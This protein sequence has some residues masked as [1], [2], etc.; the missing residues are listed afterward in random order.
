MTTQIMSSANVQQ[1]TKSS[2]SSRSSKSASTAAKSSKS[3]KN[4]FGDM[5]DAATAKDTKEA[6][7]LSGNAAA[8]GKDADKDTGLPGKGDAKD[9]GDAQGQNDA[10]QQLMA[11]ANAQNA[12]NPAA[13]QETETVS[14][15]TAAVVLDLQTLQQTEPE[16]P[17][18][19]ALLPQDK[20]AGQKSQDF[21]A[22]L[23]GQKITGAEDVAFQQGSGASKSVAAQNAATSLL[24]QTQT[25]DGSQMATTTVVA[26]NGQKTLTPLEASLAWHSAQDALQANAAVPT[27]NVA[28]QAATVAEAPVATALTGLQQVTA[29][30]ATAQKSEETQDTTSLLG[31]AALT[32]DSEPQDPLRVMLHQA[33]QDGRGDAQPNAQQQDAALFQQEDAQPAEQAAPVASEAPETPKSAQAPQQAPAQHTGASFAQTLTN[34]QNV[35]QT[36]APQEVSQART[37]YDIPRQIVDQARLIQRGQDTEMV[38]HLKPEHLGDLTLKV[39]VT[40]NGSVNASFHSQSAEVRTILENSLVQLRQDLNNQ[41]IKV[42]NVDVYAGLG[43]ELPQSDGGAAYQN[44]QQHQGSRRN[45]ADGEDYEEGLE[46]IAGIASAAQQEGLTADGVDYRI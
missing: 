35:Q 41:G 20:A 1:S 16:Q 38:I 6:D 33:A 42:D 8:K 27:Q 4:T 5:V 15:D 12:T 18:L 9:S 25:G 28:A 45:F 39:S 40:Q 37:D 13:Q 14:S 2:A 30:T 21:L 43:N 17:S 11:A 36:Q 44:P 19:Q 10:Q 26:Q 23:S 7:A 3:D 32:V 34:T 31:D 29:Q 24:Q 46:S 22:M